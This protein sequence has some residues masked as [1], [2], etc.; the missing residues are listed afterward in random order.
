MNI[1]SVL[2]NVF[3]MIHRHNP[4]SR[5]ELEERRRDATRS[6]GTMGQWVRRRF[7]CEI[8][9]ALDAQVCSQSA[10]IECWIISFVLLLEDHAV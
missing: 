2:L 7:K 1:K 5:V 8:A 4:T 9:Q 10:C 3:L 6:K